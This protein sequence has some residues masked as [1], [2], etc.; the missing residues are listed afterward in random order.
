VEDKAKVWAVVPQEKMKVERCRSGD[1][2]KME[3]VRAVRPQTTL[4]R[5]N[6]KNTAINNYII[7][8]IIYNTIQFNNNNNNNNNNGMS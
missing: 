5:I 6:K 7:Y 2:R 3:S 8:N 1:D 4:S